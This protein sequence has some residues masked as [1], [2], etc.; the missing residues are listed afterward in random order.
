MPIPRRSGRRATRKLNERLATLRRAW[1][2]LGRVMSIFKLILGSRSRGP[3]LSTP[4]SVEIIRLRRASFSSFPIF[5]FFPSLYPPPALPSALFLSPR[6]R[7]ASIF[8]FPHDIDI[9]FSAAAETDSP[10]MARAWLTSCPL[11]ISLPFFSRSITRA[12][13]KCS[14]ENVWLRNGGRPCG[15]PELKRET[16]KGKNLYPHL[17]YLSRNRASHVPLP[18]MSTSTCRMPS[19]RSYFHDI[20]G[21][22]RSNFI[23]SRIHSMFREASRYSYSVPPLGRN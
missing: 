23:S 12:A 4:L 20:R 10:S 2:T 1:P 14:A 11:T 15:F 9:D 22:L 8:H 17:L 18:P 13:R 19:A 3:R 21:K 5:F 7:I 6:G 16:R